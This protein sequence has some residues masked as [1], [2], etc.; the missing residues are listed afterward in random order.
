MFTWQEWGQSRA[1]GTEHQREEAWGERDAQGGFAQ[2]HQACLGGS[3]KRWVRRGKGNKKEKLE[4]QLCLDGSCGRGSRSPRAGR[5]KKGHFWAQD[6]GG[7]QQSW[8]TE[9]QASRT[10]MAPWDR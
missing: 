10:R 5:G 3:P 9:G 4:V 6:G 8:D 1:K 7:V 2:K